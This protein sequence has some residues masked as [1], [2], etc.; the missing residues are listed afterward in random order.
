MEIS[1]RCKDIN[2]SK[3]ELL[4]IA[5]KKIPVVNSKIQTSLLQTAARKLHFLVTEV[6]KSVSNLNTH[7]MGDSFKTIFFPYDLKKENTFHLLPVHS[8]RHG[9]NSLLLQG[10]FLWNNIPGGINESLFTEKFKKRLKEHR[11]LSCPCLVCN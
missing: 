2:Y 6:F 5:K 3:K 10:S 9:M 4:H 11:A 8:T 7:F 1:S